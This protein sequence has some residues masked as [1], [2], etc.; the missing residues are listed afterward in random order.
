VSDRQPRKRPGNRVVRR[1]VD[2]MS[3]IELPTE[4][5][6][7]GVPSTTA[8]AKRFVIAV[9]LIIIAGG[10]LLMLPIATENG[11]STPAID[12]FFTAMS[13]TS[14]TGLVTV[15]TATHWSFF[16]ELVILI[17]IQVGGFGFMVGTSVVL[18]LL[19]RGASLRDSL[20]MQDGSPT[21]SLR[22][23]TSLSKRIIRFML[24]TEAI[25]AVL[26]TAHF[27]RHDS[28]RDA[29]WN[30]VFHSISAFCNAGFDLQGDFR[31]I[32][33][34]DESPLVIMTLGGLV[35][36]GALSFMVLS[37]VWKKRRWRTL[38]LDSKLVLITNLFMI[39]AA[40][41]LFMIVEWNTAM[42][43]MQDHWKPMNAL[44]QAVAARTAGFASINFNEA[45]P[46]TLFLWV[47][48]MLV[49][50]AAGSTAGGI[51]LA[52]LAVLFLT[53]MSTLRGQEE[54]QAFGRRITSNLVFRAMS[55]V[56]LFMATHFVLSL[57][58]AITEDVFNNASIGFAPLMFEAM[59]GLA[60]VG[61]S[62]GITPDLSI[63]GKL[64]LF[65]AMFI[66]RLGPIT[67]A[68][69][70]QRRQKP[71]RYRFPEATIRIG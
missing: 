6:T 65:I 13:A 2:A 10:L 66:G 32:S 40:M 18:V 48:V 11:E 51:K 44:F 25:G 36:A 33:G 16:G 35:Q 27:L 64:I 26:L 60:T 69:A 53:V 24:V 57:S 56:A 15:D 63:P 3:I 49:G 17:L 42:S 61:L 46:S 22:D 37:D 9:S 54:P 14:V 71:A 45:H 8:H 55:L 68:Y 52:T 29:V 20:M 31:S 41:S 47:G 1:R 28:P 38:Y 62:T 5:A 30:G 58:L 34:L 19:G 67:V 23:V 39:V 7:R 43:H 4:I 21:M 70:L 59:S 12:A 50:G